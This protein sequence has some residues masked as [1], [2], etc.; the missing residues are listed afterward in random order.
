MI[1]CDGR[2]V[3]VFD[4]YFIIDFNRARNSPFCCYSRYLYNQGGVA[5]I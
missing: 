2:I 4:G 3:L 5:N 1:R